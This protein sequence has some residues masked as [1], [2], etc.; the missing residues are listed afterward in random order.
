MSNLLPNYRDIGK[1]AQAQQ[2]ASAIAEERVLTMDFVKK[3]TQELKFRRKRAAVC[4]AYILSVYVFDSKFEIIITA[5][6]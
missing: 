4:I 6:F 5:L 2:V 3:K 1:A